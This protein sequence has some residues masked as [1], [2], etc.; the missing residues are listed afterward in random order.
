MNTKAPRNIL[1]RLYF[2]VMV[3]LWHDGRI[4]YLYWRL[5]HWYHNHT[6]GRTGTTKPKG[7]I[8]I[9]PLNTKAPRNILRRLYFIVMVNL[10]HEHRIEY[11]YWMLNYWYQN[12]MVGRTG[13]NQAQ[14][15]DIVIAIP[16]ITNH[17]K[18]LSKLVIPITALSIFLSSFHY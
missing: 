9:L 15:F 12:H 18:L 1:R 5:T 4:E 8:L 14:V 7:L 13:N 3:N 11:L 2:I 10:W 16:S 17:Y 6:V